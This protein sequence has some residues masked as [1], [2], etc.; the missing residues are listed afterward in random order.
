MINPSELLAGI[1][2]ENPDYFVSAFTL[3][4]SVPA[5]RVKVFNCNSVLPVLL[6]QRAMQKRT[7]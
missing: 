1:S 7:T 6:R 3:D 5:L 4:S 2:A